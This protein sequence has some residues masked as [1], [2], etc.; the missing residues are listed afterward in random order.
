MTSFIESLS[1]TV[2]NGFCTILETQLNYYNWATDAGIPI[3]PLAVIPPAVAYRI[4]CNREPPE[5]PDPEFSGG[6]CAFNYTVNVQWNRKTQVAFVC[7]DSGLESTIVLNVLGPIL[8]LAVAESSGQLRLQIVHGPGGASRTDAYAYAGTTGCP[9]EYTTYQITAVTPTGGGPDT[10][11]DPPII[12]PPAPPGWNNQEFNFTYQDNSTTDVDIE[13]NFTFTGPVV[14]FEGEINVPVRIDIGNV[15]I[16]IN[17]TLNLNNAELNIN[18]NNNNYAPSPSPSPDD[19]RSPDDTPDVPD[20]VPVPVL[21]PSPDSPQDETT[22]IIRG[23]IVTVTEVADNTGIIFQDGNPDIFI[24]NLGYI[25]FLI[26]VGQRVAWTSDIPVKNRRN[27]IEC[28]YQGGAI[29]VEGTPRSG[30]TWSLSP[31]YATED[32]A[33]DFSLTP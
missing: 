9:A 20:D 21:P 13:G 17:G 26:A 31:V 5:L 15:N 8:G 29:S 6:Q 1:D 33:I 16:P 28:P 19:Y 22:T 14:N 25:N 3:N 32:E 27:Y 11:G 10:C 23:V 30:I 24:P 4:A 18:F 12:V 2:R 7:Q